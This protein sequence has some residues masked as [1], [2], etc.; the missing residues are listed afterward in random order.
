MLPGPLPSLNALR[1]FDAVARLGS[2][3]AA[4]SELAVTSTAVSHLVRNLEEQL[5]VRLLERTPRQVRPTPEGRTLHEATTLAFGAIRSGVAAVRKSG[6][7]R[8]L[9]VSATSA[10]LSAWLVPRLASLHRAL[11]GL[12]VRLHASNAAIDLNA[13][14]VDLAI[15][16]GHGPYPGLEATPLLVDEF[17]VVAH[18]NSPIGTVADLKHAALI[19]VEGQT[20][21]APPADWTLWRSR[22][23][24]A[25]LD[26]SGGLRFTDVALA[27]QATLAGHGVAIVS[28]LL[29]S[30][31]L[32]AGL[33]TRPIRE[34]LQGATYFMI[35]TA[36]TARRPE[37]G[38]FR[39]WLSQ[40]LEAS[41]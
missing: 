21:P 30:D 11:P 19:H 7:P 8:V 32:R 23:G 17:V 37:V 9:T 38:A 26:V 34:S 15:R 6:D 5:G 14:D 29:V 36:R 16:Y 13:G 40:Q 41:L 3:K 20:M 31:A 10:F 1:A 35:S 27:I 25:D 22:F 28:H 4:A 39:M 2:F 24:P 33:L 18:A 12:D